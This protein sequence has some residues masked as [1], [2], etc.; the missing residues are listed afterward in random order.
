M[1]LRQ[2]WDLFAGAL[3]HQTL[4]VLATYAYSV[5]PRLPYFCLFCERTFCR[6]WFRR[7][8]T[9]HTARANYLHAVGVEN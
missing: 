8:L 2:R 9:L 7:M 3:E 4:P 5:L 6:K 1:C